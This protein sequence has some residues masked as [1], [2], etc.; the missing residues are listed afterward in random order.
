MHMATRTRRWTRADIDR[1]PDDGNRYEVVDGELFVSPPSS[2]AHDVV[3][4][5]LSFRLHDF[6]KRAGIGF[7]SGAHPA[8]VFVD[9]DSHVEPDIIAYERPAVLPKKWD[10]MPKPFL[11]VEV[12]SPTSVRRDR[13][14]KRT[15]Y[16]RERV[17]DYW[18]VD[19]DA[20]SVTVVSS[21]L[22]DRLLTDRL[23]WRPAGST[24]AFELDLQEF[25]RETLG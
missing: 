1:L 16:E 19:T 5:E 14:A 8:V 20:R 4:T 13:V 15:L 3:T 11:I 25:F 17:A 23:E 21:G 7:A 10:T 9:S 6:L 18:I 24:Q 12:I 2:P 22:P